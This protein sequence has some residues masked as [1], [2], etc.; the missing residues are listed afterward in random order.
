MPRRVKAIRAGETSSAVQP[1]RSRAAAS[2]AAS[3]ARPD[4]KASA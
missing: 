1:I 4:A 2:A 3:G